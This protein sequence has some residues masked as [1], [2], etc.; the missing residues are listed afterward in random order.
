MAT[1]RY[2]SLSALAAV[3]LGTAL[4]LVPATT[5]Q[6]DPSLDAAEALARDTF[7]EGVPAEDVRALDAAGIERLVEMLGD[8]AEAP[9]HAQILEVLGISGRPEVYAAVAAAA[10]EEPTGEIDRAGLR[11]R[12]AVLVALGHLAREDDRAL[13][14]LE[15]AVLVGT[16]RTPRFSHGPLRGKRLAGLLRRSAVNALANSGRT[17]AR[18]TLQQLENAA[19]DDPE[20]E[21]HLR[22]ALRRLEQKQKRTSG[23]GGRDAPHG[24]GVGR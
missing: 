18:A 12:V 17:E 23:S 14:D 19:A 9:H 10:A 11:K 6:A 24:R 21:R 5:A 1:S 4:A 22:S 8:P 16:A 7:Y 15:A 13:A 2:R 3:L 20:F